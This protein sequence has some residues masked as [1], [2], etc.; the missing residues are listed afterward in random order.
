MRF[1]PLLTLY[2]LLCLAFTACKESPVRHE[3]RKQTQKV[4]IEKVSRNITQLTA[5]EHAASTDQPETTQDTHPVLDIAAALGSDD[6][7]PAT[8]APKR[9]TLSQFPAD[10]Q[11]RLI[12]V[13]LTVRGVPKN[14]HD[15]V[16][17]KIL[18]ILNAHTPQPYEL[19]RSAHFDS[20]ESAWARLT[21]DFKKQTLRLRKASKT[22]AVR[23]SILFSFEM[24][25][26]APDNLRASWNDFKISFR[27]E[28][29]LANESAANAE[30]WQKLEHE[31]PT[32]TI[33][34]Q[35]TTAQYLR[36]QGL[37]P[38]I[39]TNE[40]SG[41]KLPNHAYFPDGCI[42]THAQNEP[43]TLRMLLSPYAPP[44]KLDI[45][46]LATMTCVRDATFI[47]AAETPNRF[48]FFYQ[49]T[50][51]QL[52]YK[53][54]LMFSDV[55]KPEDIALHVDD[56]LIC[57]YSGN[58]PMQLRATEIQCLDRKTGK[59]RFQ[60]KRYP[61]SLRG[62]AHDANKLAFATDQALYTLTRDGK[63]TDAIRLKTSSRM[64]NPLTCQLD[65][66]LIFMTGPGQFT[67]YN[68]KTGTF[69]FQ[70][71]VLDA[72]FLHCGQRN[73]LLFSEVGGYI[74]AVDVETN[75]PLWKYRTVQ[76]PHDAYSYGDLIYLLLDRAVFVLDQ[77]SGQLRAQ[78]PLPFRATRFISIGSRLFL[79]TP[80]GIYTWR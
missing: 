25:L 76:I 51:E 43:Y 63:I 78:I 4:D 20:H 29:P 74:L 46:K 53:K 47:V 2:L 48:A 49:P 17:A 16:E 8:F 6:I 45:A 31:L 37:A 66:R 27:D 12:R 42:V 56:D 39:L 35:E 23:A 44:Q 60:T 41:I 40:L 79:D 15:E 30:F 38:Q 33:Q 52:A 70:T 3:P 36:A 21:V 28:I 14:I 61:G 18:A 13:M 75:T 69:D 65:S 58:R 68:L 24:S 50:K 57:L 22:A 7:P 34:D 9:I 59:M 80:D 19:Q 1:I 54:Q 32:L 10:P 26:H 77:K 64:R 71:A 62:I 72:D 67:A 5:A 55:L 73:T 11:T